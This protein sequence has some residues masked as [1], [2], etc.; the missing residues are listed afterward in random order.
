MDIQF[1]K[2]RGHPCFKNDWSGFERIQPV[3]V[4]I[5]RNNTGKSYLLDFI[6]ALCAGK[7]LASGWEVKW[8]V[9]FTE[10]ALI[11][12][13][14]TG[15]SGGRLGGDHWLSHGMIFLGRD[16]E[17]TFN[18]DSK[19][20]ELKTYPE[21]LLQQSSYIGI[22]E[23]AVDDRRSRLIQVAKTKTRFPLNGK[24]FRHLFADRDI[25]TEAG[26]NE[27]SLREN[28][29]GAT[30]IIRRYLTTS[31]PKY[32]AELISRDL[33]SS[34]NKIFASDGEFTGIEVKFNDEVG[35]HI[36]A[37]EVYLREEKK[38][39]IA[40][41]RSGSGLKTVILVLLNL[42]LIPSL[43][44][45]AKGDYVFA[46][47]ELENNLHPALLR[48]LL[49]FIESYVATHKATVFLTTHSSTALD[50]FGQSANAQIIHVTHDG[51]SATARPIEAHFDRQGII[52][53]LGA[54][55]SDL[56]QANGILWVEGPSDRIYLNRWIELASTGE[57]KEGRDY[58]CAC[59][60]GS[61]LAHAQFS[62]P[63]AANTELI[64]LLKVN[65]NIAV[66]CD[67]DRTAKTG[68]GSILK[69]RV[70]RIQDEVQKIPGAHLWITEPKE[71]EHYLP[72]EALRAVFEIAD[73]PDPEKFER[74]FPGAKKTASNYVTDRLGRAGIDKVDM[75]SKIVPQLTLENMKPRFDW[76]KQMDEL[77]S[78]IRQ[79]NR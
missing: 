60:G 36:N 70:Q 5:G 10:E 13:F 9:K 23:S 78:K 11:S 32:P 44:S 26:L 27:L 63:E 12:H 34:L 71:I 7:I 54:R 56:L 65:A 4:V 1:L 39:L 49:S 73:L 55:P 72:K 2:F 8:R 14:Q 46:F 57:L 43:E 45:K 52:A 37:W 69:P 62:A 67:S 15:T 3:N 50:L 51:T 66:I 31:N 21:D 76:Q 40:L 20:D 16:A 30:N 18:S 64:N 29:E 58:L 47:E 61:L 38:G 6:Q 74:F 25:K 59:Y 28:G 53:E 77:V 68:E 42:L 22:D 19:S 79:W 17:I 35:T 48:R 24:K 33:L 41:S 75:A